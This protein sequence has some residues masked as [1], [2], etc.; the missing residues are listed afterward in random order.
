MLGGSFVLSVA[1]VFSFEP[2]FL[3]DYHNH[4]FTF[5]L[6][7]SGY[8]EIWGRGYPLL[9]NLLAAAT[10]LGPFG[11]K[12]LYSAAYHGWVAWFAADAW[13]GRLRAD[14]PAAAVEWTG[15]GG[16]GLQGTPANDPANPRRLEAAVA[17]LLAN[18][19]AWLLVYYQGQYDIL[20]G[21]LLYGAASAVQRGRDL[22]GG[23][24]LGVAALLKFAGALLVLPLAFLRR[25]NWRFLAGLVASVVVVAGAGYLAF[26]SEVI[27]KLVN[28][29]LSQ[30]LES[31]VQLYS[32]VTAYSRFDP[33]LIALERFNVVYVGA[34]M[35]AAFLL[36]RRWG[37]DHWRA[38]VIQ[39]LVFLTFFKVKNVQFFLWLVPPM[40]AWWWRSGGSGSNRKWR[41]LCWLVAW[42]LA[43]ISAG[44]VLFAVEWVPHLLDVDVH[45]W[46]FSDFPWFGVLLYFPLYVSA[47]VAALVAYSGTSRKQD[48]GHRQG[49]GQGAPING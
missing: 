19:L 18:P 36:S 29:F 40:A 11:P 49:A 31:R 13:S 47:G 23:A 27:G 38:S 17:A 7:L 48:P 28:P 42:N 4:L 22:A 45:G 8:G 33:F 15:S 14:L 46:F 37:H 1:F 5:H 16:G 21:A 20:V 2:L 34:L 25:V 43:V 6:T 32:T 39:L 30:G 12:L 26:G 35:V 44:L 3:H 41:L 24:V 9:F 10:L